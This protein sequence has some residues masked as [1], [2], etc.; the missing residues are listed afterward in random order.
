[1]ILF[2]CGHKAADF[3][4]VLEN[5][6]YRAIEFLTVASFSPPHS[7]PI[8]MSSE[9]EC[10]IIGFGKLYDRLRVYWPFKKDCALNKYAPD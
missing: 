3:Q 10:R 4:S 1:M 9:Q 5:E 8:T 6:R 2:K 7:W